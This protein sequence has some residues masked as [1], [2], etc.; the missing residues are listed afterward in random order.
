MRSRTNLQRHRSMPST[1]W[2]TSTGARSSVRAGCPTTTRRCGPA[3]SRASRSRARASSDV[4]M[5]PGKRHR[6]ARQRFVRLPRRGRHGGGD[7]GA[8]RR[9]QGRIRRDAGRPRRRTPSWSRP[10]S[11]GCATAP[12]RGRLVR[13]A[14]PRAETRWA[15][16]VLHPPA[17]LRD[18]AEP[19]PDPGRDRRPTSA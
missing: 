10:D 18:R 13:S 8:A 11:S 5:V 2:S 16:R 3:C 15:V 17:G 9:A 14:I 1:R 12:R 6:S 19:D 7:Q 4:V